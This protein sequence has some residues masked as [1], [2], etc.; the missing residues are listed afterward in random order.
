MKQNIQNAFDAVKCDDALKE[1]TCAAV[2]GKMRRKQQKK[3]HRKRRFTSSGMKWAISAACLMLLV[4]SGFGGYKLYYTEAATISIDV[5]PSIELDINR[6]GRVVDEV[7]YGTDGENVLREVS[8]KHLEY[9]DA[10]ERLLGSEAMRS[11]LQN[12][13][14]VSVTLEN[15][16][17]NSR[18]LEN[19]QNCVDTALEQCHGNVT[20]EYASVDSHMCSEAHSHGMSVGKYYAIQELLDVDPMATLDEFKN[21][22][23]K[24]I[25]G[26]TEHCE[27]RTEQN[28]E[29]RD[30]QTDPDAVSGSPDDGCTPDS[31]GKCHNKHHNGHN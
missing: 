23:M 10:M 24:E 4:G 8:L 21:K 31:R 11:Y 9:G 28:G 7:P 12:N 29:R 22:S 14:V 5:N 15:S 13:A 19:L 2:V 20:A 18:L 1:R 3:T 25:R 30:G 17:G 16:N 27:H 6:W 26:H